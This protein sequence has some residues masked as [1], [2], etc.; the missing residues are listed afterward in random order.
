MAQY[1]VQDPQGRTRVIEGPDGASDAEIIAQAQTFFGQSG[2]MNT[3][4]GPSTMEKIKR[5]IAPA[6]FAGQQVS[7]M[8]PWNRASEGIKQGSEMAAE[9]MGALG[10][11]PKAA[12][13]VTL[14]FHMTPE[15]LTAI[16][17]KQP[18]VD[19][20]EAIASGPRKVLNYFKTLKNARSNA[21]GMIAAETP[22]EAGTA[23][24]LAKE[25]ETAANQAVAQKLYS[26]IPKDIKPVLKTAQTE[27]DTILNEIKGLSPAAQKEAGN[28]VGNYQDF[29]RSG[30][31]SIGDIMTEM[32]RL[33]KIA[34]EGQGLERM[35]ASRLVKAMGQDL[36]TFGSTSILPKTKVLSQEP[37]LEANELRSMWKNRALEEGTTDLDQVVRYTRPDVFGAPKTLT[38]SDVPDNIRK[39]NSYYKQTMGLQ[40]H[41]IAQALDKA[42]MDAKANVIFKSKSVADLNTAKA[43]LGDGYESAAGQFYNKIINSKDIGKE[44]AKYTPEFLNSAIGANRVTALKNLAHFHSVVAKA[45]AAAMAITG[46][47]S[48]Y[49]IYK[50]ATR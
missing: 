11:P 17:L 49:G 6:L 43:I 27:V 14:P 44:M 47:A 18:A 3:S 30:K 31:S 12:A 35:Y 32:S 23:M 20:A 38:N 10:V 24:S 1:N 48:A 16:A 45:K 19:T 36:E 25:S 26:K 29:V 33:K 4:E 46:G 7:N 8:M 40:N 15:I 39:A 42:A 13:A 2:G 22:M 41:P 34:Y 9:G 28:I 37:T 5:S 21:E 50:A